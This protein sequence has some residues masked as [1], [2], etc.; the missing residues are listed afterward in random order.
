[1]AGRRE[2]RVNQTVTSVRRFCACSTTQL[3]KR[4][5]NRMPSVEG[6]ED[7]CKR[8]FSDTV[9]TSERIITFASGGSRRLEISLF[10]CSCAIKTLR[11]GKYLNDGRLSMHDT[12]RVFLD[13]PLDDRDQDLDPDWT[14]LDFK[15]RVKQAVDNRLA[16]ISAERES[17]SS[18]SRS[19]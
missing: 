7:D 1:M 13:P 10:R 5:S 9:S 8:S 11:A 19:K 2:K 17:V 12:H 3:S 6:S 18:S 4:I 15:I 14:L 16:A